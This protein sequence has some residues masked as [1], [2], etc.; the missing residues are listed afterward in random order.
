MIKMMKM[1]KMM[2]LM[3][4]I[5]IYFLNKMTDILPEPKL[6]KDDQLTS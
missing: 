2:K 5:K 1:M 3:K 6:D 4:M